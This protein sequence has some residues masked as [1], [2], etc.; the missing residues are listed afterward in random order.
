[1][2][3]ELTLYDPAAA[4]VNDEEI[5]VFL[6]DALET[7]DA[8]F[9]AKALKTITRAK[10]MAQFNKAQRGG[11]FIGAQ[12]NAKKIKSEILEAVH[13]TSK[14]LHKAGVMDQPTLCK[15]DCL[16]NAPIAPSVNGAIARNWQKTLAIFKT[17]PRHLI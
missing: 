17:N 14:G 11:E 10:R 3:E 4:L 9:I 16:C 8:A 7:G 13:Y 5:A 1:M 2:T 15:F 6:T 12:R